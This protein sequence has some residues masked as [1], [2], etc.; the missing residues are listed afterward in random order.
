MIINGLGTAVIDDNRLLTFKPGATDYLITS[1]DKITTGGVVPPAESRSVA[2]PG[3]GPWSVKMGIGNF[4]HSGQVDGIQSPEVV[5]T[6]VMP[7]PAGPNK[8]TIIVNK[9][10][11]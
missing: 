2:P 7:F 4:S 10:E 11:K 8:Y 3:R 5:V 6:G 1:A 9:L